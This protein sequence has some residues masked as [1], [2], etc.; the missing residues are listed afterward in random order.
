[1]LRMVPIDNAYSFKPDIA[2][3]RHP[4]RFSYQVLWTCRMS[5]PKTDLKMKKMSDRESEVKN[6]N[7]RSY[8]VNFR[9][10]LMVYVRWA[11]SK[12][13]SPP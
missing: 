11:R 4:N 1:M 3:A 10:E 5:G 2:M 6:Q 12:P 7:P 9:V 8:S 13:P